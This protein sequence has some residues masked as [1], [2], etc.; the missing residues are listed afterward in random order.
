M[1]G[2]VLGTVNGP[3][4]KP[5]FMKQ[6]RANRPYC[7]PSALDMRPPGLVPSDPEVEIE[8]HFHLHLLSFRRRSA[9]YATDAARARVRPRERLC[10]PSRRPARPPEED[11]RA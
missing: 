2:P 7:C 6:L 11:R 4:E 1:V 3:G 9:P 5:L 8:F 10:V